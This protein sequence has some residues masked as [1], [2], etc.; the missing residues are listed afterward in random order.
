MLVLLMFCAYIED[1]IRFKCGGR[2]YV[3][4]LLL[5]KNKNQKNRKYKKSFC[6]G[7]G[8]CRVLGCP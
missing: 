2:I 1:N 5:L 4:A 3:F 8:V 6:D 7:C